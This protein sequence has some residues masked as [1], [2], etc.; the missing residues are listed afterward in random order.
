MCSKNLAKYIIFYLISCI[1]RLI[2][3]KATKQ[4]WQVKLIFYKSF[5]NLYRDIN[6]NVWSY[7]KLVWLFVVK[8]WKVWPCSARMAT[9][10]WGFVNVPH[11]LWHGASLYI[12]GHFRGPV[13]LTPVAE[14]LAIKLSL[15]V[16]PQ[17]FIFY[18]FRDIWKSPSEGPTQ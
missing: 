4:R 2:S 17:V 12:H 3:L 13:T 10:Q 6:L 1:L 18:R 7:K 9:A 5:Y 14:R 16:V 15:H 11:L 8:G